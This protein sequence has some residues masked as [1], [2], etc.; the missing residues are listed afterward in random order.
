MHRPWYAVE[1]QMLNVK[2]SR[3]MPHVSRERHHTFFLLKMLQSVSSA[4]IVL[5]SFP[6]PSISNSTTSPASSHCSGKFGSFD[7]AVLFNSKKH[8]VPT[9]PLP[10]ISH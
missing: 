5:V 4:M 8:P 7:L 10:I 6:N 9:V 1:R 3:L 2:I